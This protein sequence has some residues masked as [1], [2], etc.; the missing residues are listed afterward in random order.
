MQ[1][2]SKELIIMMKIGVIRIPS[3]SLFKEAVILAVIWV[4]KAFSRMLPEDF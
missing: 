4:S 2:I 1:K 3:V